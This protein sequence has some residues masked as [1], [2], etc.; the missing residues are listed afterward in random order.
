MRVSNRYYVHPPSS[1]S[2]KPLILITLQQVR[3]LVSEI[4]HTFVDYKLDFPPEDLR[5]GL[6]IRF[7]DHSNLRP[8]FLGKSTSKAHF[9]FL[10]LNVPSAATFLM[11]HLM[12]LPDRRSVEV[13]NHKVQSAIDVIRGK[14]KA[15][16]AKKRE[17]RI[18]KQQNVARSLKR[19]QRYLGL[20]P[21]SQRECKL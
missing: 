1:I 3:E 18:K 6:V 16:K 2:Q 15:S 5:N 9:N 10:E 4:N 20:R 19:A 11:D 12:P 14:D 8:R 21:K 17:E 13:F 7:P